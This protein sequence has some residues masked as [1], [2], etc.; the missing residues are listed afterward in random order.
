V[1][2]RPDTRFS[3]KKLLP[4][5]PSADMKSCFDS[6]TGGILSLQFLEEIMFWTTVA[7][8]MGAG[9]T[10]AAPAG[11]EAA[12]SSF[13]PII[14]MFAVFYFLLIRPQ[15]KRTK[16]HKNMLASLKRGDEVV[17]AGG[18]FGRIHEIGEEHAILDLG[19]AKI[20]VLRSSI[21][22]LAGAIPKAQEKKARKDEPKAVK[23]DDVKKEDMKKEDVKKDGEKDEQPKGE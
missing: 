5:Y 15:Q 18:I 17:T 1:P 22:T 7:Y 19:S 6:R 9:G 10:G 3:E 20:K 4:L 21:S 12:F 8:A 23:K 2:H 11:G 13:I 16:E 14:L